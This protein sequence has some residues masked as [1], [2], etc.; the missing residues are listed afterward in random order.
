MMKPQTKT[1]TGVL[2]YIWASADAIVEAA[3]APDQSNKKRLRSN[4]FI[5]SR[6]S[7]LS[8]HTDE[9]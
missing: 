3:M 2:L 8:H 4:K 9:A 1:N 6:S 7:L 5:L